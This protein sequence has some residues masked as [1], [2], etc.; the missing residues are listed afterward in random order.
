MKGDYKYLISIVI[1]V[2]NV[3]K[4]L[5]TSL[6][7]VF[8]QTFKDYEVILVN[9]GSTDRSLCICQEYHDRYCNVTVVNKVNGG[10]SSARNEGMKHIQGK[11]TLFL[12]S[13]DY[14]EV[15]TLNTLCNYIHDEPDICLFGYYRDIY[16]GSHKLIR[17][18]ECKPLV[19]AVIQDPSQIYDLYFRLKYNFL[20][21]TS[22]NK[23]YKTKFL[24]S[25]NILFPD[26]E[27]YEDIE[28]NFQLLPHISKIKLISKSFYH[29]ISRQNIKT[30]TN[31]F[32]EKKLSFLIKRCYTMENSI[33]RKNDILKNK[34]YLYNQCSYWYGKYLYSFLMD[35]NKNCNLNTLKENIKSNFSTKDFQHFFN[36]KMSFMSF[37]QKI[38]IFPLHTQNVFLCVLAIKIM[39]FVKFNIRKG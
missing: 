10:L 30:I 16:N 8:Q 24:K 32:N 11:Y 23:L 39:S 33:D 34:D 29:Y 2:Y 17:T 6:D 26:K 7:S 27:L 18:T 4:F 15:D 31:S 13:D 1:P 36:K 3:E 9:D 37:K 28:F 20:S 14:L 25:S 22:W 19:D 35:I 5:T 21:D 12:D 38:L